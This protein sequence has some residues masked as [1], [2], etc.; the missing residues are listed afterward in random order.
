M[1]RLI[2]AIWIGSFCQTDALVTT[3]QID[4]KISAARSIPATIERNIGKSKCY[5][6][7]GLEGKRNFIVFG[8]R[9]TLRHGLELG[10]LYAVGLSHGKVWHITAGC[11]HVV[12]KSDLSL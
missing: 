12:C 11:V 5:A 9:S 4:I 6:A 3:N 8:R 1:R 2:I 10:K 7:L